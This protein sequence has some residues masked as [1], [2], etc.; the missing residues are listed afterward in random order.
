MS[1]SGLSESVAGLAQGS[2]SR[3]DVSSRPRL[4]PAVKAIGALV[5]L[6]LGSVARLGS[7]NGAEPPEPCLDPHQIALAGLGSPVLSYGE[8]W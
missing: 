5:A 3:R 1:L 6:A 8:W 2:F 4:G 7:P